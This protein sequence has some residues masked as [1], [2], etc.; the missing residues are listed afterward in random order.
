LTSPFC[1]FVEPMS[2]KPPSVVGTISV[3][4]SIV[5]PPK[6]FCQSIECCEYKV[7]EM[8]NTNTS[9]KSI[10]FIVKLYVYVKNNLIH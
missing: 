8:K 4:S 5:V 10:V 2:K 1:E 9:E 3:G 7:D 6:D